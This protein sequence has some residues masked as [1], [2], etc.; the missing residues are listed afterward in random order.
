MKTRNCAVCTILSI[1]AV[2]VVLLGCVFIVNSVAE[3]PEPDPLIT[4]MYREALRKYENYGVLPRIMV[5]GDR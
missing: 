4:T 2:V 3:Q 1:L 5:L